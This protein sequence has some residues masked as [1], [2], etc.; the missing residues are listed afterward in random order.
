M[1]ISRNILKLYFDTRSIPSD[2]DV[3]RVKGRRYKD[4]D[5]LVQS[6]VIAEGS[7]DKVLSAQMYNQS[8]RCCKTVY[9]VLYYLL[10]ETMEENVETLEEI[11]TVDNVEGLLLD[12]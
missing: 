9:E 11:I 5:I 12:F 3:A 8:V 7:I 6:K 1:E 4:A 2:H 10:L